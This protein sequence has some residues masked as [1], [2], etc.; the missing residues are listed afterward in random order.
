MNP[1]IDIP[2]WTLTQADPGPLGPAGTRHL[3]DTRQQPQYP[4]SRASTKVSSIWD[5]FGV[6]L[7]V[8]NVDDTNGNISRRILMYHAIC[9]EDK[10]ALF[11]KNFT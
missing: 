9:T 7:S 1:F 8:T 2:N 4:W 3:L 5:D 6:S 10:P 11:F